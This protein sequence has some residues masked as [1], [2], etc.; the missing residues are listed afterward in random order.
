VKLEFEWSSQSRDGNA[1]SVELELDGGCCLL[2]PPPRRCV[3]RYCPMQS[4]RRSPR[5]SAESPKRQSP[6]FS[7]QNAVSKKIS[8]GKGRAS[9]G[10]LRA[11]K[12]NEPI[13]SPRAKKTKTVRRAYSV[14]GEL[15]RKTAVEKDNT[16]SSVPSRRNV[17]SAESAIRSDS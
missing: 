9:T 3:L 8:A 16:I 11:D 7:G 15:L 1:S 5:I 17:V 14:G 13:V 12:E 10:A 4:P 2:L 6:R